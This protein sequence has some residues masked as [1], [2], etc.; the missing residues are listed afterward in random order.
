MVAS[1]YGKIPGQAPPTI[2]GVEFYIVRHA[3][4]SPLQSISE[5]Y[6]R[7]GIDGEIL[8]ILG[9]SSSPP[10]DVTA[11]AIAPSA[12]ALTSLM[13]RIAALSGG[14]HEMVDGYGRSHSRVLIADPIDFVACRRMPI[15][16]QV[17]LS[18]SQWS[19]PVYALVECTIRVQLQPPADELEGD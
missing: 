10:V 13:D 4:I 8:N 18:E 15:G 14:I 9:G 12:A 7:P 16:Y 17:R 6:S 1:R 2:G 5:S 19:G 3:P 11:I